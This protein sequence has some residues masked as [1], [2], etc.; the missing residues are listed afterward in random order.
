MET[1][2]LDISKT[3]IAVSAEMQAKAQAANALLESGKG[4]G[5]DFL[6]WVHLPS[7]I[8]AAEIEAIEKQ[9][10]KLREKAEVIICIGIG[11]SYLGAKAV[12]VKGGHLSDTAD[13]LLFDGSTETWFPG[14]RIPTK[15]TH[16]TGCTLSS[17][18]AANLAKGLELTDAVR[19]SKA[20]VTEA[21]EHGIELGSGCGPTHHFVDLYRKAGILD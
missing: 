6:G 20:Y 17:S 21:I 15:N 19:A 9:A 10:A 2:K 14:K 16:G 8:S 3:G 13:D 11:G 18:L 4:A 12:L 7:S 1:I 5:N